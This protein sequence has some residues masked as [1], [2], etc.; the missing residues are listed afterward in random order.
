MG[1]TSSKEGILL[2][3]EEVGIA[4]LDIHTVLMRNEAEE[5]KSQ[6][7][8][9]ALCLAEDRI[10]DEL[11][12]SRT[13]RERR[14]DVVGLSSKCNHEQRWLGCDDTSDSP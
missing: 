11:L 13:R 8:W 5:C 2:L 4:R 12:C 14:L 6:G 7:Y 3:I 9:P 10:K 1:Q